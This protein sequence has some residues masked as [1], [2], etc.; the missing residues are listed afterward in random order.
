[1]PVTSHIPLGKQQMYTGFHSKD[2]KQSLARLQFCIERKA[3]AR[4][5]KKTC[6]SLAD[7]LT[8]L[9]QSFLYTIQLKNEDTILFNPLLLTS[10][11]SVLHN[12]QIGLLK[13]DLAGN[14]TP[15]ITILLTRGVISCCPPGKLLLSMIN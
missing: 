6:Q 1:M 12:D 2:C 8:L 13:G 3:L 5:V 11:V 15:T 9:V 7:S 14:N 4:P 10:R